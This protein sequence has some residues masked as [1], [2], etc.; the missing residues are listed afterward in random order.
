MKKSSLKI[1]ILIGLYLSINLINPIPNQKSHALISENQTI[2]DNNELNLKFSIH[3]GDIIIGHLSFPE[4]YDF[5]ECVA[6]DQSLNLSITDGKVEI[7]NLEPNKIYENILLTLTD[8]LNQT[9]TFT[10]KKFKT[11]DK[12]FLG[13]SNI[14]LCLNENNFVAKTSLP[15]N[16]LSNNVKQINSIN[17]SDETISADIKDNIIT[18][19]NLKNNTTY[20]DLLATVTNEEGLSFT[21]MLNEFYIPEQNIKS[22]DVKTYSY[23]NNYIGEV[24]I[25]EDIISISA[26]ISDDNVIIDTVDGDVTLLDLKPQTTYS[27]LLLTLIDINGKEHIFKLKTFSTSN[28]NFSYVDAEIIKNNNSINA[29]LSFPDDLK[30]L[31]AKISNPD[32]KFQ[33]MENNIYLLDLKENT[34]YENLKLIA[35]DGY[36]KLHNFVINKFSTSSTNVNTQKL[37]SYIENAYKKA[38]NRTELDKEGFKFWM[39]QLSKHKI[40]SRDFILNILSTDEFIKNSKNS[41]DKIKKIYEVMFKRTPDLNGLNYWI[42]KYGK[43]LSITKNEKDSVSNLVKEMLQSKEFQ[44]IIS[45]LGIKY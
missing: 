28:K 30:I 6:S 7:Y 25:P 13:Y 12:N 31:D 5:V 26:K 1:L 29:K 24:S 38:F 3:E 43:Y 14:S 19:K 2:P 45:D 15:Q 4:K 9:H 44:N 10:L 18:L 22:L 37:S 23:Q 35:K 42:D 16:Y 21:F 20:K 39:D 41:E 34:I 17:L 27:N 36:G 33:I 40:G 8:S 11:P 32:I